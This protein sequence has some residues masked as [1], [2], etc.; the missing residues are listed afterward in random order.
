MVVKAGIW[1]IPNIEASRA[2]AI[3]PFRSPFVAG[4]SDYLMTSW[5][6]CAVAHLLQMT[7][8]YA[9]FLFHLASSLFAFGLLG[10]YFTKNMSPPNAKKSLIILFILPVTGETV[11]WVGM[12][13]FTFLILSLMLINHKRPIPFAFFAILLG[14]QHFEIGIISVF[15]ATLARF[16]IDKK[17]KANLPILLNGFSGIFGLL[18]GKYALSM[19]FHLNHITLNSNRF[20]IGFEN[21]KLFSWEAFKF[22]PNI[23]W[24]LLGVV[25]VVIYSAKQNKLLKAWQ[26]F[27][28]LLPIFITFIVGDESRIATLVGFMSVFYLIL[29]NEKIIEMLDFTYIRHLYLLWLIVPWVWV[30]GVLRPGTFLVDLAYVYA[31]LFHP[32]ALPTGGQIAGWPF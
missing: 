25:W 8:K 12:D 14:M 30:W 6:S 9:F 13:S 17:F 21:F 29:A 4:Q 26:V 22:L 23:T 16:E 24:S 27:V 19:I 32:L 20:L 28:L 1:Y 31:R 5:L 7:S 18:L 2:I 15:L 11:Y 3:N 10:R